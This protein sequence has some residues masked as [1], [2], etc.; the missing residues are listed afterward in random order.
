MDNGFLGTRINNKLQGREPDEMP[1]AQIYWHEHVH[2]LM[3]YETEKVLSY[4][5][6]PLHTCLR[7]VE[8]PENQI[9][10]ASSKMEE[11]VDYNSLQERE[12]PE[13]KCGC[14]EEFEPMQRFGFF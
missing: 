14:G 3:R 6:Y 5:Q 8:N 1:S 9:K 2:I 12:R 13:E 7:Q 11:L 4:P 10:S